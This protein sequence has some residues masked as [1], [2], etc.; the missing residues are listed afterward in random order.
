MACNTYTC[1]LELCCEL[2]SSYENID[3]NFSCE[4]DPTDSIYNNIVIKY[5]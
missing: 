5:I 4:I 1:G 3:L 2:G